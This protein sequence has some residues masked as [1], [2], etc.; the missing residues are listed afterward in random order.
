METDRSLSTATVSVTCR[1]V[2][3]V[4]YYGCL[5]SALKRRNNCAGPLPSMQVPRSLL[6]C[7]V[8]LHVLSVAVA[9]PR[10]AIIGGGVGGTAA[11]YFL[12]QEHPSWQIEL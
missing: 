11:A 10:V 12:R 3:Q 2:T 4:A 7:L 6:T 9:A 1:C 5:V 8:V